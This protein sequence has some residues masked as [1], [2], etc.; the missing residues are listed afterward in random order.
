MILIF[1]SGEELSQLI[2]F[3]VSEL[4]GLIE[5]LVLLRKSGN[6]AVAEMVVFGFVMGLGAEPLGG[7][8]GGAIGRL[9]WFGEGEG[10]EGGGL[11]GESALFLIVFH[12]L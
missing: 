7:D 11:G 2:D 3:P 6:A 4:Q 5:K 9:L 12:S 10:L 8:W 1:V